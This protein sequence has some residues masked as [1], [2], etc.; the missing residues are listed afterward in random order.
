M[1]EEQEEEVNAMMMFTYSTSFQIQLSCLIWLFRLQ[2][3]EIWATA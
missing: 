3:E 2:L 1:G